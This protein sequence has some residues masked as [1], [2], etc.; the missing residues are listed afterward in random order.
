MLKDILKEWKM[1]TIIV[2]CLGLVLFAINISNQNTDVNNAGTNGTANTIANKNAF[3]ATDDDKNALNGTSDDK[4]F[5]TWLSMTSSIISDDLGCIVKS[6]KRKNFTD[7]ER[8][9]KFLRENSDRTLNSSDSH[10]NISAHLVP[11]LNQY[12]GAL[13]NYS[14]G[15]E[16]LEMGAKNKNTTQMVIASNY[17]QI[18]D[19]EM[20]VAGHL[21]SS[22][23]LNNSSSIRLNNSS[24]NSTG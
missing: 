5:T 8:C 20:V 22:I 13:K 6:A 17:I 4:N 10:N 2:I 19:K 24:I 1:L 12:K 14:I 16:Y 11:I 23:R 21:Y 18:A 15:G 9:A 7:T 3:N